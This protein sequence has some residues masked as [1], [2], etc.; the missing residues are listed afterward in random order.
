[1]YKYVFIYIYLY[2]YIYAGVT[3]TC[4]CVAHAYE[5]VTHTYECVTY[6]YEWKLRCGRIVCPHVHF[7]YAK[8]I[9][10]LMWYIR[11]TYIGET[12]IIQLNDSHVMHT[13]SS[14]TPTNV[15]HTTLTNVSHTTLTNVSHITRRQ[16][17]CCRV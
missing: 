12:E 3:H 4:E 7:P 16:R 8:K 1:M 2:R 14:C 6:A 9:I 10:K 17:A 15:S 5:C 13:I 11:E